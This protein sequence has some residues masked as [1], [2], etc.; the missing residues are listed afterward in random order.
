MTRERGRTVYS[1]GAGRVCPTCGWPAA[2]CRCSSAL[3]QPVPDRIVARLRLSKAGRKGKTVTMVEG[4]PANTEFLKTLARDLKKACGSGGTAGDRCVE[5][6]GDQRE[7]LR[8]VLTDRG[9]VVK[10]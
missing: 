9:W 1:T 8:R 3:E 2:E 5:I 6:Q 7:V 4:L 10:G